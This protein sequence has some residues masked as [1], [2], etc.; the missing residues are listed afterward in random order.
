MDENEKLVEMIEKEPK[1]LKVI[2]SE[3]HMSVLLE[4]SKK[5]QN[6]E[7][8]KTNIYF[9]NVSILYNILDTLLSN[10]LIKKTEIENNLVYFLTDKGNLFV[11][12]YQNTKEKFSLGGGL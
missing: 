12:L 6:N 7:E 5:S 1:L 10:K 9:K 2:N 11:N 8:L 4:I 3:E